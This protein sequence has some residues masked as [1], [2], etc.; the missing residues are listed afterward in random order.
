MNLPAHSFYPTLPG[1]VPIL[2]R[3]A[4][5][6]SLPLGPFPADQALGSQLPHR[7][8]SLPV[9]VRPRAPMRGVVPGRP[10]PGRYLARAEQ[11]RS[12]HGRGQGVAGKARRRRRADDQAV[13]AGAGVHVCK[14][15]RC[16]GRSTASSAV[17]GAQQREKYGEGN[18]LTTSY[19][20]VPHGDS[21]SGRRCASSQSETRRARRAPRLRGRRPRHRSR[22]PRG[23]R[24][25]CCAPRC[26]TRRRPSF[27]ARA[28]WRR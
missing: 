15:P 17:L 16:V 28:P 5:A 25:G 2:S 4:L 11:G 18:D 22:S 21:I 20:C 8:V 7:R 24:R 6:S 14:K 19:T 23:S 1:L 3:C 26:P 13:E 9:V 10:R 12:P 27:D